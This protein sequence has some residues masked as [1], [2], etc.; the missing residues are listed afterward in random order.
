MLGERAYPAQEVAHLL[1]GLPLVQSTLSFQTLNLSKDGTF[2]EVEEHVA[3]PEE[4]EAERTV[5]TDS[6][7]QR[8]AKRSAELDDSSLY[9]VFLHYTWSKNKWSRRRDK[10]C[11]ILRIFPRLSP[12]PEGEHYEDYC[13]IKVCQLS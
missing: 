1:L 6:W 7:L 11:V 13:R 3:N 10:T 2:R 4:P 5:T 9:N 8:Y 12:S